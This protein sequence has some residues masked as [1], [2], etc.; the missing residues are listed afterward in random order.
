V[1]AEHEKQLAIV[2]QFVPIF[3]QHRD[4]CLGMIREW[5]AYR[6][7]RVKAEREALPERGENTLE[8][9][10]REKMLI[11]EWKK[12]NPIPDSIITAESIVIL[13]VLND[14]LLDSGELSQLFIEQAGFQQ[15]V[16]CEYKMG[17][18][19]VLLEAVRH[20]RT[21]D[22]QGALERLQR[23]WPEQKKEDEQLSAITELLTG[24]HENIKQH[25][26]TPRGKSKQNKT[27]SKH[28]PRPLPNRHIKAQYMNK[29]ME[30]VQKHDSN[31]E[32]AKLLIAW[33]ID[34][35]EKDLTFANFR[36]L[37][38]DA[39]AILAGTVRKER[40]EEASRRTMRLK[41]TYK[42]Q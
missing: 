16:P 11:A 42:K 32:V 9:R 39:L 37:K 15:M 33:A 38:K 10:Q 2:K 19:N 29:A 25:S 1:N 30:L 3:E 23:H 20:T 12:N 34:R 36:V 28:D 22:A 35:G 6:I 8:N 26:Q 13:S 21:L 7:G 17:F 18:N 27:R 5:L 4:E 24:I 41:E 40:A 14:A 31:R